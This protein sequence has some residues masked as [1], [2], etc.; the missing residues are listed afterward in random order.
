MPSGLFSVTVEGSSP[1]LCVQEKRAKKKLKE[2]SA[3]A[4]ASATA[5]VGKGDRVNGGDTDTAEVLASEGLVRLLSSI[6]SHSFSCAT[7]YS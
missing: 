5:A 2:T 7:V 3:P 6:Y 4:P 1:Y